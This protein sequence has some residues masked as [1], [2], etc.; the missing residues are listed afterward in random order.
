MKPYW[1][2]MLLIWPLSLAAAPASEYWA[3]WDKANEQNSQRIDHNSWNLFLEKYLERDGR[4]NTLVRYSKVSETDR[5]LLQSYIHDLEGVDP[6]LYSRGVQKVYWINLYNA[7]TVNLILESFADSPSDSHPL[8]SITDLG[9]GF[10]SFGPWDDPMT[11][12]AGIELTLNDIEHRILRPLWRDKRIHYAVNCASLGCPNLA[13]E[14]YD[15][16]DIEAQLD[17]AAREFIR[18]SKGVNLSGNTLTLSSIY[19]WYADDFGTQKQ[20]LDHLRNFLDKEAAHNLANFK[21]HIR[22]DYN[23]ALNQP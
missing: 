14:A 11:R 2:L 3:I 16:R 9:E 21:G 19:D 10:F 5:K 12:V 6:R 13:D 17:S 4:N 18:S 8:T 7:L 1:L 20:L 15:E 22:Y 23:W